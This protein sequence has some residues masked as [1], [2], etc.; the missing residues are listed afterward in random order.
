MNRRNLL[1]PFARY[2]MSTPE[3]TRVVR[4]EIRMESLLV[5]SR[6]QLALSKKSKSENWAHLRDS[7]RRSLACCIL[8]EISMRRISSFAIR[9]G[10]WP[11]F[12]KSIIS[13][14]LGENLLPSN[15]ILG[16]FDRS[17]LVFGQCVLA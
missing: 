11:V 7:R 16:G 8:Y 9:H 14:L 10:F 3:S 17:R 6:F 2:P 5:V 13:E 15:S 1:L 12:G 4:F